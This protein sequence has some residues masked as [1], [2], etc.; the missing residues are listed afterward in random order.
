MPERD[1]AGNFERIGKNQANQDIWLVL[2]IIPLFSTTRS[3]SFSLSGQNARL[4]AI[5]QT[6]CT[7]VQQRV[8]IRVAEFFSL[9]GNAHDGGNK[10]KPAVRTTPIVSMT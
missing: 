2:A 6:T 5:P 4:L 7:D 8:L 3:T 10:K 1:N 9:A